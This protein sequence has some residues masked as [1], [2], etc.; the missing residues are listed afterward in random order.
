MTTCRVGGE[1]GVCGVVL[2]QSV[3]VCVGAVEV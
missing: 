2:S 1:S 3:S